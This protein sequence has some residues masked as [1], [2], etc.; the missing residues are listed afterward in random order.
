MKTLDNSRWAYKVIGSLDSTQ[1]VRY[2]LGF[3]SPF[4]EIISKTLATF[5][6][7]QLSG[8]DNLADTWPL[9]PCMKNRN[10]QKQPQ[11]SN[12]AADVN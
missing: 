10:E 1:K 12:R 2:I 9:R 4:L 11:D 7:V 8:E 3:K 5:R 6:Y